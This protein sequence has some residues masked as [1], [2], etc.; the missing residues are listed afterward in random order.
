MYLDDVMVRARTKEYEQRANE[1]KRE[2]ETIGDKI[3]KAFSLI[4]LV[5][6]Y[7]RRRRSTHQKRGHQRIINRHRMMFFLLLLL[8]LSSGVKVSFSKKK[9]KFAFSNFSSFS[10]CAFSSLSSSNAVVVKRY[11]LV[12]PN[13]GKS[14]KSNH[15]FH[16]SEFHAHS[17]LRARRRR[18]RKEEKVVAKKTEEK[19]ARGYVVVVLTVPER[20]F[21]RAAP[22]TRFL[23]A[24]SYCED[25][26]DEGGF[27]EVAFRT[28]GPGGV[29]G[30]EFVVSRKQSP[31]RR[32]VESFRGESLEESF[33][34]FSSS[35]L[36]SFALCAME[37]DGGKFGGNSLLNGMVEV[38]DVEPPE[39]YAYARGDGSD[40]D[41]KMNGALEKTLLEGSFGGVHVDRGAWM[42]NAGDSESIREA[43][44]YACAPMPSKKSLLSEDGAFYAAENDDDD[45]E[46]KTRASKGGRNAENSDSLDGCL[47][48]AS[49]IR[50][51]ESRSSSENSSSS[52]SS[53]SSD[54]KSNESG[55]VKLALVYNRN[56]GRA[57]DDAQSVRAKLEELLNL[58]E[59]KRRNGA[60][61]RWRVL[62]LTHDEKNPPCLLSKCVGSASLVLTP[63]G[64]QSMLAIFMSENA[65]LYEVFPSRYYKH[66][67]KRFALEFNLA[68]GYSQSKPV[69]FVSNVIAR[70]FTTDGCMKMYYCRYLS[71]KASVDVDDAMLARLVH[72]VSMQSQEGE[73]GEEETLSPPPIVDLLP[74]RVQCNW[75]CA[76]DIAC[77]KFAYDE[78]LKTCRFTRVD[79]RQKEH[80]NAGG[81]V[82]GRGIY[83]QKCFVLGC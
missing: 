36:S 30:E 19:V 16:V 47:R 57:I 42:P 23:L 24:V 61:A 5:P 66:G 14:Y 27:E 49:Q 33:S 83:D 6:F 34:S 51:H 70:F 15:W 44:K 12:P 3:M 69:G 77:Q 54:R 50:T 35:S 31:R 17:R 75:R 28:D 9:K 46:E 32:L 52:S 10:P 37:K 55:E 74:N 4:S 78:R 43:I 68:H 56:A 26:R 48:V 67:Y 60:V 2:R 41:E 29:V 76:G 7:Q 63:H 53:S 72:A 82:I 20:M 64:F 39:N 58:S 65:L 13:L 25:F 40:D 62:V 73:E 21:L 45:E 38:V 22:T 79:R 11:S 80:A 1:R 18:R 59:K 8:A 81:D 71:R